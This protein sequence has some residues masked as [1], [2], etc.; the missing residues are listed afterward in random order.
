ML[1]EAKNRMG[2]GIAAAVAINDGRAAIAV[3]VTDDL[4]SR[5]DAVELVKLGVETLGGKGGG[6]RADMAQG[7]G[8]DASQGQAAIDAVRA[9]IAG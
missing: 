7:G 3:A 1:D 2:S 5:F 6:G 4:V 8:P 9:A